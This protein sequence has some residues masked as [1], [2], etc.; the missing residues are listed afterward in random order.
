MLLLNHRI[1]ELLKYVINGLIATIVHY[2]VLTFNIKVIGITSV[3]IA[4]LI[5]ACFGICTSFFGNRY[6]VFQR[7]DS[8]IFSQ[9]LKFSYLYGGI[10]LIHGSILL[11]WSDRFGYDYRVGFLIATFFQFVLSYIGNKKMV[12]NI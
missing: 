10:A 4:N 5:A 11:V 3:G 12:F 2:G 7:N 1:T 9:A 6:F 8:E